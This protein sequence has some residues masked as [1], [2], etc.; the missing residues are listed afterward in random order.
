MRQSAQLVTADREF[1]LSA[2]MP[3]RQRGRLAPAV[4]GSLLLVAPFASTPLGK[5]EA[6]L[7]AYAAVMLHVDRIAA[8]LLRAQVA[9]HAWSRCSFL[10][11]GY[12][13]MGLIGMT[14]AM[15]FPRVSA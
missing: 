9:V 2:R 4:L 3:D 12:L 13:A 11:A 7:S 8:T 14:R 6:L 15:T 5:I 10:A 1:L